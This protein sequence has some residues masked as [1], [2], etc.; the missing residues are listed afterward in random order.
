[1]G[2][3]DIVPFRQRRANISAPKDRD[4]DPILSLQDDVDRAFGNFWNLVSFPMSHA[5][6][7][8]VSGGESPDF[9][10]DVRDNGK[11]IEIVA[12]LPGF[13]ED[14]VEVTAGPDSITIR[15]ERQERL[16]ERKANAVVLE[17]SVG[18]LERTVPLPEG[19]LPDVAAARFKNGALTIVVPKSADSQS[20]SKKIKVQTY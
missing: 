12:D 4:R 7:N 17:R 3:L 9:K 19:S 20:H 1:M 8:A 18:V 13:A 5:M 10:I 16:E 6:L 14:D 15:A 2:I 11:E